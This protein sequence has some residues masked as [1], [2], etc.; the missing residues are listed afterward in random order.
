MSLDSLERLIPDQLEP[1]EV[2]GQL[3]LQLHMERY[4]FAAAQLHPGRILDIACGVGYGSQILR[5]H[6]PHSQEVIGVDCCESTIAYAREH[7]AKQGIRFHLANAMSFKDV[8]EF[9][10]IVSLETIEHVPD[11]QALIE[12][13]M[14]LLRPGGVFIGSVPTTPTVDANPHHL[15]DFTEHSFLRLVAPFGLTE[16]ARLPQVQHFNPL[17][18]IR[19][20]EK[21]LADLRPHLGHYYLTHP[22][23]F[24][25]RLQATLCFGFA[26]HYLTVAWRKPS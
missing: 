20:K 3:T 4:Q 2:T 24:M 16:I 1:E 26:N 11:P 17:H 14:T 12:H 9:D 23:A 5:E 10:S 21:R 8:E 15:H 19:R 7:Y 6:N 13:L 25:Q 18:V 22:K